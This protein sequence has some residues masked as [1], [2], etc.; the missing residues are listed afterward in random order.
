MTLYLGDETRLLS[1]GMDL[2]CCIDSWG[3][4]C[5]SRKVSMK[6][7]VLICEL[8]SVSS[9]MLAVVRCQA[10]GSSV[11]KDLNELVVTCQLVQ[12]DWPGSNV[13]SDPL[14]IVFHVLLYHC[15]AVRSCTQCRNRAVGED[16][17]SENK[18]AAHPDR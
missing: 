10:V 14:K 8:S 2:K 1:H 11:R 9:F 3:G 18:W 6:S 16:L 15:H 4:E 12:M 13:C 5:L 7:A 17:G